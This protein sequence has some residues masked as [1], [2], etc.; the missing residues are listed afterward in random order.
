MDTEVDG[1][2]LVVQITDFY[3]KNK[4]SVDVNK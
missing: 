2:N 4:S 3:F 1:V